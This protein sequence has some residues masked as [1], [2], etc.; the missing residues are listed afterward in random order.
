MFAR[1]PALLIVAVLVGE[2]VAL[3]VQDLIRR[4]ANGNGACSYGGATPI[5]K[6]LGL[7]CMC[8]RKP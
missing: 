6:G 3:E 7:W 8:R 5:R 1:I 4:E 2:L